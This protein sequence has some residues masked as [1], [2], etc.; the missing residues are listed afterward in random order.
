MAR[1]YRVL[2]NADN[3]VQLRPA[4]VSLPASTRTLSPNT[5]THI[6]CTEIVSGGDNAGD[7]HIDGRPAGSYSAAAN[8]G[9]VG[10]IRRWSQVSGHGTM[11]GF[12][13]ALFQ[14]NRELS[15]DHFAWLWD[16]PYAFLEPRHEVLFFALGATGP[17]QR[18]ALDTLNLAIAEGAPLVQARSNRADQLGVAVTDAS[19]LKAMLAGA[20]QIPISPAETAKTL[21]ALAAIDQLSLAVSEGSAAPVTV[22]LARAD[23][24]R[25]RPR[26][27]T[28]KSRVSAITSAQ[29][30][31]HM[32]RNLQAGNGK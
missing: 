26:R 13:Y 31:I 28:T 5:Y 4:S 23:R 21:T 1:S 27:Q 20:D 8:Y 2:W 22:R 16:D 6:R 11:Q 12:E 19:Q 24:R 29:S 25:R 3:T 14:W 30:S 17:V 15:A 18:V 9:E 7:Y 32:Q 10:R